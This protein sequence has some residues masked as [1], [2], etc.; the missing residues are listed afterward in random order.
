[1]TETVGAL[2]ANAA[3]ATSD[4]P[5]PKIQA[6]LR[7]ARIAA[8]LSEKVKKRGP[9]PWTRRQSSDG[10]WSI[11]RNAEKCEIAPPLRFRHDVAIRSHHFRRRVHPTELPYGMRLRSGEAAIGPSP[12]FAALRVLVA[13]DAQR[14]SVEPHRSRSIYE[15]HAVV[16]K[17]S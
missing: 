8:P 16:G 10:E 9:S 2:W 5:T 12:H 3:E 4:N 15:L 11:F 7:N 14:T 6:P 1:M 17:I 13:V